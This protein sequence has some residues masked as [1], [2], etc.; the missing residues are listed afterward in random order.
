MISAMKQK[1]IQKAIHYFSLSVKQDIGTLFILGSIYY[2][3]IDVEYSI[4][5]A[6]HYI[7]KASCFNDQYSKNNLGI[8]Y[9]T[10]KRM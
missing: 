6:I 7:K 1:N 9:K 3:E 10:E 8:I 5:K 2:E 4:Q